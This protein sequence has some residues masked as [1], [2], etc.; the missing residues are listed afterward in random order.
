[1]WPSLKPSQRIAVAGVIDPQSANAA[2]STPWIDMASFHKAM[3]VVQAG[4]IAA[5]GTVDAKFQ[6]ATDANGTG[7]K[8]VATTPITQVTQ[9][10]AGSSTQA[11]INVKAAELDINNGFRFVRLTV[12][13]AVAAAFVAAT[14]LGVDQHFGMGSDN[15]AATVTQVVN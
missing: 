6:Q 10:G 8:D 5:G 9:A 3:A 1:M 15:N 2:V 11:L 14:V 12:T 13:P 4:A 7:T